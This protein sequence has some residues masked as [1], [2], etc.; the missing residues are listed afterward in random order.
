MDRN[1]LWKNGVFSDD[2]VAPLAGSVD[3]NYADVSNAPKTLASLP[4]RGAW[5]EISQTSTLT[6]PG[7]VAPLAGSVDRNV[8][9]EGELHLGQE[10]LPS[11]GAWIEM[12]PLARLLP[13]TRVAPLA[14]SVDRNKFSQPA[15]TL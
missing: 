1:E 11:R 13:I 2:V 8:G 14:G 3:R 6:R 4:S 9:A 10:S 5:I 15:L 7:H 12:W